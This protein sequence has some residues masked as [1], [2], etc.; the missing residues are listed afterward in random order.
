MRNP[1]F[2]AIGNR[3]SRAIKSSPKAKAAYEFQFLLTEELTYGE[4][5]HWH[6]HDYQ[7]PEPEA[8]PIPILRKPHPKGADGRGHGSEE[9][10][11]LQPEQRGHHSK[12][13]PGVDG[14]NSQMPGGAQGLHHEP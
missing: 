1:S 12:E 8:M 2:R 4:P 14:K 6:S 7:S 10:Q 11:K 13:H 3:D 9:G 5:G